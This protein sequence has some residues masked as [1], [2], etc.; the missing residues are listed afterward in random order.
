MG[1]HPI[2]E[3]DFDC[4]TDMLWRVCHRRAPLCGA[5]RN[6]KANPVR[7]Q[8]PNKPPPKK[9]VGWMGKTKEMGKKYGWTYLL[10]RPIFNAWILIGLAYAFI[11]HFDITKGSC[12]DWFIK[13]FGEERHAKW[14]TDEFTIGP[15]TLKA[16]IGIALAS[17]MGVQGAIFLPRNAAALALTGLLVK[18]ATPRDRKLINYF[19]F[20]NLLCVSLF[21]YNRVFILGWE[22]GNLSEIFYKS[23]L[24]SIINDAIRDGK[25]KEQV[26]DDFDWHVL[27][28][29]KA[30]W[31]K[32]EDHKMY[33]ELYE[34]MWSERTGAAETIG[35]ETN[36]QKSL[37]SLAPSSE[38][39]KDKSSKEIEAEHSSEL[40]E[41]GTKS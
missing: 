24:E 37:E 40:Y 28:L 8:P 5:V 30:D 20:V 1:T 15:M 6:L 2:F 19:L 7:M 13:L 38:I 11:K 35:T 34:K 17:A 12:K 29:T 25:S 4:L 41:T 31:L 39:C 10:F 33:R 32:E 18:D 16:N 14:S 9:S 23:V 3:S 21:M 22:H 26:A 27:G 36:A